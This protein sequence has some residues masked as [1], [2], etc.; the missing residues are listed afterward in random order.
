M[1]RL[2]PPPRPW[3]SDAACLG[4]DPDIFYPGRGADDQKA[5]SVCRT[6]PV[7]WDC[8]LWAVDHGE[9]EGIWGG[10]SARTRRRMFGVRRPVVEQS[11]PHGSEAGYNRHG[12]RLPC[13]VDA[14]A[15]ARAQRRERK[16]ERIEA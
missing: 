1:S 14:A 8:L 9:R 6:C 10:L 13:C 16:A 2:L 3:V 4:L 7:Q 15:L 11:V 12:C 5:K